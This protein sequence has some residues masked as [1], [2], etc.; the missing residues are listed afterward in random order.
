MDSCSIIKQ[1]GSNK[2]IYQKQFYRPTQEQLDRVSITQPICFCKKPAH[3]SYTLEY[4]PILECANYGNEILEATY[5][6][7]FHVHEFAWNKLL[8]I[9]SKKKEIR[10][11]HPEFRACSMFNLTFCSLF[12][13]TNH[14][15][16]RPPSLPLCFCD[17]PVIMRETRE[18]EFTCQNCDIEGARPKCSWVLPAQ[19]IAYPKPDRRLHHRVSQ[20]TYSEIKQA[21]LDWIKSQIEK[22]DLALSPSSSS[23]SL[24]SSPCI[25]DFSENSPNT[26][27]IPTSVLIKKKQ[28]VL[29]RDESTEHLNRQIDELQITNDAC[30]SEYEMTLPAFQRVKTELEKQ[31]DE[32]HKIQYEK[33]QA[34]R[35]RI[36]L[37]E[38]LSGL[39][40]NLEKMI[41]EREALLAKIKENES[42]E[43][44]SDKCKVCYQNTIEYAL[45]PCF[46][47]AYCVHCIFMLSECAICR[48]PAKGKQKIYS[49]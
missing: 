24:S 38:K 6:C 39:E 47:L 31:Q 29:N 12:S 49:C 33:K 5:V 43:L 26:T 16:K 22:I 18:I 40:E 10:V 14:Y 4:G 17:R 1:S 32:L 27:F 25:T 46:H 44:I 45:T 35:T 11:D 28:L 21:R 3:K 9:L 7:G 15:P 42:Q 30:K 8:N 37:Q 13:I 41:V 20:E 48:M 36:D 23:S 19:Q 34:L 2:K